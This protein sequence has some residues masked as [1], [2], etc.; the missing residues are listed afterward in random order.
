MGISGYVGGALLSEDGTQN[1]SDMYQAVHHQFVASSLAT[2]FAH[3]IN[4]DIKVGMM[5]ARMQ[6]YPATPN[7]ADVMEEIKRDHENLFFSDVQVRG[8][9]Q[10][11]R[12]ASLKKT[13]SKWPSKMAI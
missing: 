13:A 1:L 2:K 8:S 3:E 11:I 6:A 5:L 9:I 10:R 4:P 7:P 12:S